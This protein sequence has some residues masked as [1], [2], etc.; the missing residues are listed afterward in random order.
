M[1][2]LLLAMVLMINGL[3][4]TQSPVKNEQEHGKKEA[5][6]S[7]K[8]PDSAAESTSPVTAPLS[9]PTPNPQAS[10]AKEKAGSWPSWTD[11]FWPTWL[12]VIVTAIAVGAALKT[13]GAINAQVAEMRATGIQTDKLIKENIAQTQSMSQQADSLAKSA[14][15]LGESA[16]A[17]YQS[18]SAMEKIADKIAASTE[19][20]TASVSAINKQMRDYL[21]VLVGSGTV[22]NRANNWKFASSPTLRNAGNTPAHKVSFKIKTA[23]L[24]VPLPED[25]TFPLP[26]E[27]TGGSPIGPHQDTTLNAIADDFCADEEVENVKIGAKGK[28]LYVWGIVTYQDVFGENHFTKFC[29]TV[30]FVRIGTEDRVTGFYIG[31][32]EE[33][34]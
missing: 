12:L 11:I 7:H 27:P 34:D 19:A 31:R 4:T 9:R 2:A 28:T 6:P 5:K 20:A 21:F 13:L 14:Y 8:T 33:I 29:H 18:A 15:H 25:F 17:T 10:D 24:P 30:N 26:S 3:P 16:N 22:Q 32:H 23:I 1:K